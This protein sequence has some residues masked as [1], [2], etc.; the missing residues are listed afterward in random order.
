MRGTNRHTDKQRPHVHHKL[1]TEA[2]IVER[3]EYHTDWATGFG[4]AQMYWR[5]VR[6]T[7]LQVSISI[8]GILL[9]VY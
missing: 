2:L 7:W 8:L 3:E 9:S 5:N 6:L 4:G 1:A